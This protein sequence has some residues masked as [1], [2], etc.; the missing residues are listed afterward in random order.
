[1]SSTDV[2]DLRSSPIKDNANKST[3]GFVSMYSNFG[4]TWFLTAGFGL[5]RCNTTLGIK[6]SELKC[7]SLKVHFQTDLKWGSTQWLLF[8]FIELGST[9][10]E[11]VGHGSW[12]KAQR[13]K[14]NY[15][16]ENSEQPVVTMAKAYISL[17]D[18]KITVAREKCGGIMSL[19]WKKLHLW[20]VREGGILRKAGSC[21]AQKKDFFQKMLTSWKRNCPVNPQAEPRLISVGVFFCVTPV[22]SVPLTCTFHRVS[23]ALK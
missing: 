16:R 21:L 9:A 2:S 10:Q 23:T 11:G 18:D 7:S 6:A 3:G 22:R 8:V 12:V 20:L 19:S 15:K 13:Q 4:E 17:L 1:M 5:K 14:H